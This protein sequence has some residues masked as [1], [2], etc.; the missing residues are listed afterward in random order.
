MFNPGALGDPN[1][2]SSSIPTTEVHAAAGPGN[3]WY[4]LLAE[5]TNPAGKPASSTCNGSTGL[6]GVGIQTAQ[7]IMY[8][9]MLMKTTASS[10]L[11]YRSWTMQAAKNLDATG[12]LC[13]KTKAAWDA[14]SVPAQT[15]DP[16][17][18]TGSP[19]PTPTVTPTGVC[20]GQILGNPGFETGTAP[21]TATAGVIGAPAGQ[22]PHGG[23]RFA[24]LDGYGV[25]HTDTLQQTVTIPAG[26]RA[27]LSFWLHIDTAE[28]P[29]TA[30]DFLTVQ[31]G[32]TTVATFSNLNAA[33]GYQLRTINLTGVSGSVVLKF[34]GT[35][36]VSLQTSF[37][38]DDT[39]L[40]L[41]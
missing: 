21:W 5:G 34:T 20:T 6:V 8:N 19:S 31:A 16:V 17:C 9:A 12:A 39:S 30:F 40:T 38:I 14:V 13:N 25:T 22:V 29:G 24:W 35:E 26:C 3:H 18:T 2:Y 28:G 1:C 23:T 7:R 37:V 11:R 15:T 27:T 10:Y 32:S 33:A 4:Y 36:D 41:S